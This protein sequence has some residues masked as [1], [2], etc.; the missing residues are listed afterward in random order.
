[1]QTAVVA[2]HIIAFLVIPFLCVIAG[3]ARIEGGS[4]DAV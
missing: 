2:Y 3:I 4:I 1:M